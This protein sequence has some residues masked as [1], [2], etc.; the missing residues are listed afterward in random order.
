MYNIFV[1]FIKIAIIFYEA[2]RKIGFANHVWLSMKRVFN[3][4]CAI[5]IKSVLW[6]L[7]V[8][9]VAVVSHS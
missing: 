6:L 4:I 3:D 2:F 1:I 5:S 7:F 8:H 9:A